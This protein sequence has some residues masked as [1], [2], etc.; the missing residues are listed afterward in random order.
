[1]SIQLP[2]R[3]ELRANPEFAA[4]Y[5]ETLKRAHEKRFPP[6]RWMT[7][8]ELAKD[9][10]P[11]TVQTPALDLIDAK[12]VAVAEKQIDRLI[13]TVPPQE[14]KSSR[15]TR[16]Y[17]EWL[18]HR[19]PNL[20]IAIVSYGDQIAGDMSYLVRSDITT[21]DGSDDT[22]VNLGLTLRKDAKAVG[23]WS[24]A[25]PS[26]GGVYAVGIGG[27]LTSKPVDFMIIDDPVK[28]YRSADSQVMSE[29]A[30]AW[31]QSVARPRLAPGAP[32]ILVQT[33]WSELDLA[34]RLLA[35][36][37]Q[38]EKD[39]LEHYDKWTVLNIPAQADHDPA[40]GQIDPLGREPGEY[41]ISARGRT[42]AEWEAT[43]NATSSR[44]W[45]AVYQGKPSPDTGNVWQRTWWR[46]FDT[47]LWSTSDGRAFTVDCDEM[48]MSW[49]M[50]F[51]DTKSSDFVVGQVFARKGAQVFLVDQVRARLS[52]TDSLT[53]F[54]KL[55]EKWPQ[56]VAKLVE[57]KANGTAV[58]DSLR[59][60]IPGL[61]PVE[62]HGSKYARASAVAPFIEAGN[63]LLPT[64]DIALFDVEGFI[65]ETA[66]FPN[67]AHD[68]QV[69]ATSQALDRFFLRSGAGS[70]FLAY[71]KS[72]FG[73]TEETV[74]ET[75]TIV[76]PPEVEDFE[77][78]R[79]RMF[80]EARR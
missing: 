57:D 72:E 80:Q 21:F 79:Q 39:G 78:A 43:K 7:P 28:D 1:M 37:A 65:E 22:D 8:G 60:E 48:L 51:K 11:T 42:R 55:V 19:N 26:W 69:D 53:A 47:P 4:R 27:S 25:Q 20:R 73:D 15:I 63:V 45:A 50:T 59:K 6:K 77:A 56:C 10:D 36:Q 41:M 66:G 34:G 71:L 12:L 54:K 68:D 35:K 46:R 67:A 29:A 5:L 58:M 75:P 17:V 33:R 38:D 9:L 13:V 44:I 24:L 64:P 70:A 30:W 76:E 52:F 74:I 61:I 16:Y 14:G 23:R 32:V 18:L 62:P 40:K 31:Y 49:D 2:S 3:D